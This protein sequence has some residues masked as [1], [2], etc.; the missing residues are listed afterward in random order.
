L[1]AIDLRPEPPHG[2][3]PTASDVAIA[4]GLAA[5]VSGVPSTAYALARG[6]DPLEGAMAAGTLLLPR[7]RRPALLLPA[8][9][10]V[11]L[12]LSFGWAL[13]LARTLPQR[14]AARWATLGGL[15][16]AALDLGVVGRRFPAI[17]DLPPAPQVADHL[18]YAWTVAAVLARRR[19]RDSRSAAHG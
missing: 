2:S 4:G 15:A 8:A 16:I 7:E 10:I 12:T 18:A 14:H 13:V 11:H 9:T 6:R 3:R 1:H 17:R 5:I 19:S